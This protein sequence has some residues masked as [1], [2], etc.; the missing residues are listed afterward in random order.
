MDH[1]IDHASVLNTSVVK[2]VK[3]VTND[4][5]SATHGASYRENET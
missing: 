5:W 2:A 4:A 1:P 3:T